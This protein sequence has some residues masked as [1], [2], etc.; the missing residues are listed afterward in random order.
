MRPD[1]ADVGYVWDMLS[2][3]REVVSFVKQVDF[4]A[5]IQNR[6]LVRAVERSIQIIGEAAN[7]VSAPFRAEHDDIPWQ[8]ISAQRHVLVHDYGEID[9]SRIWNLVR[10]EIPELIPQLQAI[11]DRHPPETS[12]PG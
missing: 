9:Q 2:S 11:I 1:D 7:H 3:A 10:N 12:A 6:I 8:K 4:D 5:Y